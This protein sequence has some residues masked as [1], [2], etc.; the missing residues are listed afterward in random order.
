MDYYEE[1]SNNDTCARI[2]NCSAD[3]DCADVQHRLCV[4]GRCRCGPNYSW[5]YKSRSCLRFECS[6][7]REC[8]NDWDR[9]RQCK[10][11]LC[12]CSDKTELKRSKRSAGLSPNS[13]QTKK[14]EHFVQFKYKENPNNG[15]KCE[16]YE[17][18]KPSG[19]WLP[20]VIIILIVVT[21][22]IVCVLYVYC[23]MT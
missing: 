18:E 17:V 3:T 16:Q 21:F 9:E 13:G 19:L 1:K 22:I 4:D 12:H 7:D 8:Q 5:Q 6:I 11:G 10:H 23:K 20:I 15:M 2:E 14:T